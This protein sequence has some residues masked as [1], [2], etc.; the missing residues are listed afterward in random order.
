MAMAPKPIDV[1][2][3][4]FLEDPNAMLGCPFSRIQHA[5]SPTGEEFFSYESVRSLFRDPR[6][7]PKNAQVF[8]DLGVTEDSPIMKFVTTGN[9]NMMSAE[10]HARIRPIIVRGFRPA[11]IKATE[12][13]IQA[14]ADELADA[15]VMNG[16]TA[17]VVADYSH[18]VSIRTISAFIGV[19]PEDIDKFES[20]SVELILLSAVPFEPSRPRLEAALTTVHAYVG[21]LIERRRAA[22][23]DDFI[24]D[25]IAIQ[26]AGEKLSQD[27]LIWSIVFILLAGHDTTRSQIAST[28]RMLIDNGLWEQAYTDRTL[29]ARAL[30]ESLRIYPAAYRFARVVEEDMTYGDVTFAAGGRVAL[31]LAAAGRDPEVFENPDEV[32]LDRAA[33]GFD[34][35]FGYGNHHCIGWALATAE[36]TI[37]VQ[38]LVDRLQ[39]VTLRSP[40]EYKVGGTIAGPEKVEIEFQPRTAQ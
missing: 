22:P 38:T 14:I 1:H 34:I 35:G 20:A 29:V 11:R 12:P 15:I 26:D 32:V 24:S 36:I 13:R 31:N 7:R 23:Q 18:Y 27:E 6:V 33:P 19:P 3:Q 37:G 5:N 2:T 10:D 25:L 39:A 30:K 9:F 21:S 8:R 28:A 4:E 17:N 40:V 16:S